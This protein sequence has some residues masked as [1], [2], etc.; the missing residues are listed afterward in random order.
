MDRRKLTTNVFFLECMAF[1]SC[2]YI[3]IDNCEC[4]CVCVWTELQWDQATITIRNDN[5]NL[6]NGSPCNRFFFSISSSSFL[7]FC[8]GIEGHGSRW[9]HLAIS[10]TIFSL[11]WNLPFYTLGINK[12]Q[13]LCVCVCASYIA[14][15]DKHKIHSLHLLLVI[16]FFLILV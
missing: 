14:P 5:Y 9:Y 8:F 3:C 11:N 13:N 16:F 15:T 12:T 2:V 7:G 10:H 4:V 6:L 1:N